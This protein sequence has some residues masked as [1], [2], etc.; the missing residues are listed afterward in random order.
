MHASSSHSHLTYHFCDTKGHI[1]PSCPIKRNHFAKIKK[2]WVPKDI[3][4]VSKSN[5]YGPKKIWVPIE[6]S[7]F[8]R[9]LSRQNPVTIDGISIVHIQDT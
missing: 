5:F 3:S 6:K 1:S 8:C 9:Y 4:K 2:M 7:N